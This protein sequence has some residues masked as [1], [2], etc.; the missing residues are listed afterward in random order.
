M[1][2][3]IDSAIL[4][5]FFSS[6]PQPIPLGD[7]KDVNCWNS[8]WTFIQSETDLSIQ[9]HNA[10]KNYNNPYFQ[11]YTQM[12]KGRGDSKI[13]FEKEKFAKPFKSEFRVDNPY[14][15]YCINEED[16]ME[17]SKYKRKNGLLIAFKNDYKKQWSDLKILN[18]YKEIPVRKNYSGKIFK[19]WH[20]LGD[21]LLPFTD[22]VLADNY[23]LSDYSLV[24]SNL[25]PLLLQLD[26]A[27]PVKYNLTIITYEDQIDKK[28][29]RDGTQEYEKLNSFKLENQ[30]NCNL[31]FVMNKGSALREHDRGIFMNYLRI[32]S[33]DSFNY[34]NSKNEII[35]NG[36]DIQ[37]KSMALPESF[38][39]AKAALEN[40]AAIVSK[41]KKNYPTTHTFGTLENRL[42]NIEHSKSSNS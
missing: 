11:F 4:D 29:K 39:S 22:I 31:S 9:N 25:K 24:E 26:K 36:T 5:D 15:F 7:I 40:L 34:F 18:K 10:D 41:M 12:T 28:Y 17:Q 14:T 3:I 1:Y 27:T 19:S 42:L 32:T 37:F 2:T 23:L 33:G 30:L 8:F 35:T 38:N 6:I 20:E 16:E 21:Y 13:A